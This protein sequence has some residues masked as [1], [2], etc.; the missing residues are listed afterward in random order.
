MNEIIKKEKNSFS[1]TDSQCLKGIAI[2]L[3]IFHHCFRSAGRF[4]GYTVDF[5]PFT[6]NLVI[7]VTDY[8]NICVSIFAFITGYGLYLSAKNKCNDLKS[9]EKWTV[10]RLI[11]TMSG[12][13]FVYILSFFITEI[14]AKYPQTVYCEEGYTRGIFYALIDLFGLTGLFGTPRMNGSWWYMSAVIIFVALIPIIIKWTKKLGYMSLIIC[15]IAL[16]RLVGKGY[17]G[18]TSVYT[19]IL[20]LILGMLF[21]QYDIFKKLDEIKITNNKFVSQ[22]IQFVF[23]FS[24]LIASIFA[25]IRLPVNKVWE[26]HF[27]VAPIISIYFCKR[28]I[29]R[30][31]V[32]IQMLSVFG[33]Y[34]MNIFLIHTFIRYSFFQDFT[35]SFEKFWLIALVLF[36][37]SLVIS[38]VIDFLKKLMKY[39]KIINHITK[40]I[41]LMID[42]F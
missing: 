11:K 29:V 4:K 12:F 37:I 30:I 9:T 26:Y 39:D 32:I 33:K 27:A 35:Y 13:Y 18:N 22:I 19:F 15:V 14:Y 17:S 7:N 6:Q 5:S 1:K 42:K 25:W 21:A 3:L 31:P 2:I 28:Y 38:I 23:Y 16:P 24:L 36:A 10:S 41:C 8:F 20:V 34:S 40:Y